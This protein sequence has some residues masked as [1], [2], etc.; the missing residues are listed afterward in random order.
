MVIRRNIALKGEPF[1]SRVAE[2]VDTDCPISLT[3]A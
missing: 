2:N 3:T 1:K